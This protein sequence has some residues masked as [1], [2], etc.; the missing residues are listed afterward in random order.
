MTE[1]QLDI[2]RIGPI[3]VDIVELP[4]CPPGEVVICGF[5]EWCP[6][7]YPTPTPYDTI[8]PTPTT[9]PCSC[10]IIKNNSPRFYSCSVNYIECSTGS[11]I[12]Y[13]LFAGEQLLICSL[14]TPFIFGDANC[15][16]QII[17]NGYCSNGI[18][19]DCTP[20]PTPTQTPTPSPSPSPS[21]SPTPTQ[22]PTPTQV[23]FQNIY[24]C[25]TDRLVGTFVNLAEPI[26]N[27]TDGVYY[28]NNLNNAYTLSPPT[29]TLTGCYYIVSEPRS[30]PIIFYGYTSATLEPSCNA[31]IAAN[32]IICVQP[33]STPTPSPTQTIWITLPPT[34]T[35]TPTLYCSCY[36]V[37]LF[38]FT[39]S[40]NFAY[41]D[42]SGIPVVSVINQGETYNICASSTPIS[43]SDDFGWAPAGECDENCIT[44]TPTPSSTP[45]PTPTPTPPP[46]P[47]PLECT[48]Y[49]MEYNAGIE[50]AIL[51]TDCETGTLTSF[52]PI[53]NSYSAIT[54]CSATVPVGVNVTFVSG[55][56]D[57]GDCDP[58]GD[59]NLQLT[60]YEVSYSAECNCYGVQYYVKTGFFDLTWDDCVSGLTTVNLGSFNTV[61]TSYW[62]CSTSVPFSGNPWGGVLYVSPA[63][64][65]G[66]CLN[67]DECQPPTP[68][69]QPTPLF[70]CNCYSLV[71]SAQTSSTVDIEYTD[72]D[73][74]ITTIGTIGGDGT[75]QYLQY[76]ST[77]T[78]IVLSW[79]N[80]GPT[81]GVWVSF[82][83]YCSDGVTCD[84]TTLP[85]VC[86]CYEV[87][88][89]YQPPVPTDD[90][91][92]Y[93]FD[94]NENLVLV[95]DLGWGSI[96]LVCSLGEPITILD[97]PFT[98]PVSNAFGY[99]CVAGVCIQSCSCWEVE[100]S[101][102]NLGGKIKY[103]CDNLIY[104]QVISDLSGVVNVCSDVTPIGI[105]GLV[106]ISTTNT[107]NPCSTTF[108]CNTP[109]PTQTPTP[110]EVCSGCGCYTINITGGIACTFSY[111][112]CDGTPISLSVGPGDT[113][114]DCMQCGS[115]GLIG[116]N[117]TFTSSY[118]GSCDILNPCP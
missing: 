2:L 52:I 118:T 34:A 70:G 6:Y 115:F 17:S 33:T 5:G 103:G 88:P 38:G 9:P 25:C 57:S 117:C 60:C 112:Q 56:T 15:S 109:S 89:V 16:V 46:S 39:A 68:T 55:P 90:P 23:L 1:N 44:P 75:I 26:Y 82:T 69:P 106:I 107:G 72:C 65:Q 63:V 10:Y 86:D 32:D 47:T 98:L 21:S 7:V 85:N 28:F 54:L 30:S 58:N 14:T 96:D 78:P 76:C 116:F 41:N 4:C 62:V 51:Y 42:C 87:G 35:P 11:A 53:L 61:N 49:V 91:V 81:D 94:C 27:L 74:G 59:C 22:T 80:K 45:T 43:R 93:Y 95:T 101:Q 100:Y 13:L 12:A 40:A 73:T 92:Y 50:S 19:C 79:T 67:S 83:N 113:I 20:T 84:T 48:C 104:E 105:F 108:D 24:D 18:S 77:S 64:A 37:F 29:V 3:D 66:P 71:V 102:S 36:T 97:T 110:T 8:T 114:T 31:C 111:T 99:S